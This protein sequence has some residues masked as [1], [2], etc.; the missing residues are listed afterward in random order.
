MGSSSRSQQN[1]VPPHAAFDSPQP[2]LR[3][4]GRSPA[5][6]SSPRSGRWTA[7]SSNV[8]DLEQRFENLSPFRSTAGPAGGSAPASRDYDLKYYLELVNQAQDPWASDTK[9]FESA[10]KYTVTHADP[11]TTF[12]SP[13]KLR[14]QIAR[15]DN[16][17]L[18]LGVERS[19]GLELSEDEYSSDKLLQDP[20]KVAYRRES[21]K[22]LLSWV[23]SAPTQQQQRS[24]L[25]LVRRINQVIQARFPRAA[26][27]V[28]P[29]GSVSWGGE[30]S[31]LSDGEDWDLDLIMRVSAESLEK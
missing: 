10:F 26:M 21:L 5:V 22:I 14:E 9:P 6:D 28:E 27:L 7:R 12:R 2:S 15:L 3:P 18:K 23:E 25:A 31:R 16:R 11:R 1:R 24:V 30:T 19:M 29:F 17:Y 13:K 4:N 20:R 8:P